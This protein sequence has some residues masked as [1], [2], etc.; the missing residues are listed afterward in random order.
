MGQ[1]IGGVLVFL[2]IGLIAFFVIKEVKGEDNTLKIEKELKPT[3]IIGAVLLLLIIG[4]L[5]YTGFFMDTHYN[6]K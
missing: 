6:Y 1:I 2:F 4:L 5:L 3:L